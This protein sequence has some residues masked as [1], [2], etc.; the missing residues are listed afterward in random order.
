M[1]NLPIRT[2]IWA[3]SAGGALLF[4]LTLVVC[5]WF[6]ANV[7][8]SR[9][10]RHDAKAARTM[11]SSILQER[12][13]RLSAQSQLLGSWPAFKALIQ[14]Q[15]RA[16]MSDVLQEYQVKMQAESMVAF[17]RDGKEIGRTGSVASVNIKPKSNTETTAT[18]ETVAGA[19]AVV[20]VAPILIHGYHW[21]SLVVLDEID[22]R[23]LQNLSAAI[24]AEVS[25]VSN[26]KTLASSIS[27]IESAPTQPDRP[28]EITIGGQ[29]YL[30]LYS[31][32]ESIGN[33]SN[34]GLVT[35][36]K[37]HEAMAPFA[38]I[39]IALIA[40]FVVALIASIA[41][42][43][44]LAKS[45]TSPLREVVSA[46]ETLSKGQWPDALRTTA[47]D[48]IAILKRSF[49]DMAVALKQG[50]D[51]LIAMLDIDPLTDVLNHRSFQERLR[52]EITRSQATQSPLSLVLF[53]IDALRKL[54]EEKGMTHGD[55]L[56][57]KTACTLQMLLPEVAI[58]G[59]HGGDEF[60]LLLPTY[61]LERSEQVAQSLLDKLN[62]AFGGS[63]RFH[64]GCASIDETPAGP[65]QLTLAAEMASQ[66]SKSMGG[67][68]V[69][70]FEAIDGFGPNADPY[71]LQ[72][73]LRDGS[74]ATIQA[75]AAAVDA[76]DPY[77]EGHSRRV[78]ELSARLA[79]FVGLPQSE[80]ELIRITGTL[81]DVGKIGIPDSILK[82]DGP[83]D[84]DERA[85]M[86]T[87]P[88]LGEIIV[89]KVPQLATTLPGVRHHHETWN[90]KGYPDGLT[91][92]DI[93]LMARILALSDSFDAM[94]SDR[95]YRKGMGIE[96]A[97]GIIENEL[98]EQFD[99][100]L[101]ARF[102]EMMGADAA[103]KAA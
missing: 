63:A 101:G 57:K 8:S 39:R 33:N 83:M 5:L 61:D 50:Q 3:L 74:L 29:V 48:E 24:G 25:I 66:M 85:L 97:L 95:P 60:A 100:F 23:L 92:E 20:V 94:T 81:H 59:R 54:N 7:E 28:T 42:G 70:R 10:L 79:Q 80:V 52:Q 76:K 16:T 45:V 84:P 30:G 72:E 53:D 90:G 40:L 6:V 47:N 15:D 22:D 1:R 75:L 77:T 41:A 78:A 18:I 27:G 32:A 37:K 86:E 12:M 58:I 73:F 89:G 21:G 26:G 43:A 2:R 67:K 36:R 14:T 82:K 31:S 49:N 34:V 62:L 51:K 55:E 65:T 13:E 103:E 68:K 56:L 9:M 4:T 17:D 46:A 69:A 87:H 44:L 96:K 71:H 93:P 19:S 64:V 88:V 35:L 102:L 99:P 11:F 98:G 91:G 38:R